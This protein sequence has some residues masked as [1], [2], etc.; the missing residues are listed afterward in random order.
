[1]QDVLVLHLGRIGGEAADRRE[2][3]HEIF[4]GS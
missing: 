2:K 1:M 4:F 3:H